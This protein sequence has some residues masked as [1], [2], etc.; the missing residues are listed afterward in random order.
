MSLVSNTQRS[1]TRRLTCLAIML[2]LIP[3]GLLCR[4]VPIGLPPLIVKYGG[5]FLWAATVYWFIAF[6]LA[7]QKPLALGL[8]SLIAT[9]AIEFV[10][11]IQSPPLDLFRDTFLGKVLLGRY[12]SYTDIAVYWIAVACAVWMDHSTI[13]GRH[14]SKE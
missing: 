12:F 4:F 1:S 6:L 14:A 2:L 8:I 10:K 5:S 3:L 9:A 7:R 13:Y 11:Q